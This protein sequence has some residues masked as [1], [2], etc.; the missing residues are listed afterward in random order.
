MS[1]TTSD[2][3]VRFRISLTGLSP[4]VACLPMQFCYPFTSRMPSKTPGVLL[5]PVS[6]SPLS[7]AATDGISVDFFSSPYLDVSVQAVP[8]MRLCIHRMVVTL[9]GNGVSP[10]GHP[11][12]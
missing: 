10:F 2:T 6:P 9:A 12:I 3:A 5:L 8:S 11:R 4:S 1:R 7:L